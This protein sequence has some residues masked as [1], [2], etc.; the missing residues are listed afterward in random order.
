MPMPSEK[1]QKYGNLH[2]SRTWTQAP[3]RSA[4]SLSPGCANIFISLIISDKII[5]RKFVSYV[6]NFYDSN[7]LSSNDFIFM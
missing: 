7:S 3:N 2:L 1:S 4:A 6:Q 5:Y